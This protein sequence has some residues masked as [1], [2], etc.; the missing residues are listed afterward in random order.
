MENNET[1]KDKKAEAVE[2][3]EDMTAVDSTAA[4]EQEELVEIGP[5]PYDME[6]PSNKYQMISVNGESI[7]VERGKKTRVPK[8]FAIAYEHRVRM[9][10]RKL[11]ERERRAQELREKQNSEGVAFL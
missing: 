7:M 6:N 3:T 10:G 11:N 2:T 5:V 4:E 9:A 1:K 8:R